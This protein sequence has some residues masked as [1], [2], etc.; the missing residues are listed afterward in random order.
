M[1]T[2]P[3]EPIPALRA[4]PVSLPR[5]GAIEIELKHGVLVFRVSRAVQES[6]ERLLERGRE[7][8]LGESE[9]EELEQYEELDDYLSYV[10]RLSRNIVGPQA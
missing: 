7:S 1:I 2:T 6:I 4:L 5:E 3:V 9:S 8:K 10:N